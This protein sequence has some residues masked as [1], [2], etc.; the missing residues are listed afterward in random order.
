MSSIKKRTRTARR[1]DA[2]TGQVR[3]V[4]AEYWRARYRDDGGKEHVRHFDRRVDAQKWLDEVTASLVTGTHVAPKTARMTVG[5]WC[6]TWLEGYATRRPSTVR[7]ARV[8][9]A[10]IKA[11]FGGMR[12]ST[13]RPSHVKAWTARL[14]MEGKQGSDGTP[15]PLATSYV[16][17]C[18]ARLA[19]IMSDAVHDGIIPRSPCS[20]RTSPGQGKQRPYV[21]TTEQLWA[22][23]DVMPERLRASVLIGALAGLRLAESCGLRISDVDFMRGI[24]FPRVQY[25]AEELKT[26]ISRTPIPVGQSLA[27]QLSAHVKKW[28]GETLLIGADGGQLSPWALERA[29]RTARKKVEGLPAGFR[30]HDLRHYFASLLIAHGAD[31]KTVQARLRHGSAKTTLDTYGHLWPDKDESTKAIID[32]VV[33]AKFRDFADSVR[34]EGGAP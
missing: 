7:Q 2:R 23:H 33:E 19:Q 20:R 30:Y 10:R 16:Y 13:V 27:L 25:P 24:V 22:L 15:G 11:E 6:D 5:D 26:E 34:T 8:H 4:E 21:A 18:H 29:V 28:P 9:I 14:R 3:E 12:L 31:V 32:A 17:A 1:K